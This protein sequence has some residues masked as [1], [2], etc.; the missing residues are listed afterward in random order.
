MKNRRGSIISN[1][2]K[3]NNLDKD[4]AD[5]LSQ[6]SGSKSSKMRSHK[7]EKIEKKE[8]S[9]GKIKSRAQTSKLEEDKY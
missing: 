4:C 6:K 2:V 1:Y 3:R 7:S 8:K 5:L 9:D